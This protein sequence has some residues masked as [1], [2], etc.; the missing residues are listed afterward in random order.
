MQFHVLTSAQ[1]RMLLEMLASERS[2]EEALFVGTHFGREDIADDL[3][4]VDL[5]AWI[6]PDA[7]V[8]TN[9]GHHVAESLARRLVQPDPRFDL[10][11]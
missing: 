8:F 5:A 10:S 3:C 11:C 2:G 7:L 1:R 9:L 4:E 6:S